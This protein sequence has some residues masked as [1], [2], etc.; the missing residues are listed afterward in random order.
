MRAR[1]VS[2]APRNIFVHL[3]LHV[4]MGLKH[5]LHKL[6]CHSGQPLARPNVMPFVESSDIAL[7]ALDEGMCGVQL[8]DALS[9]LQSSV[10]DMV[11][12][13]ALAAS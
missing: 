11:F 4:A 1:S 13:S 9:C 3:A 12:K 10:L 5:A 2:H 8:V 6:D 7:H